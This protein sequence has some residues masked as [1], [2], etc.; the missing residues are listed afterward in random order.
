MTDGFSGVERA[1]ILLQ[2][3]AEYV[4]H[5]DIYEFRIPTQL[6]S[7]GDVLCVLNVMGINTINGINENV[8]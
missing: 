4:N 3:K 6:C 7:N 1:L 5:S 8:Q 2:S